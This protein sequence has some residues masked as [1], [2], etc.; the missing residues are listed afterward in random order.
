MP[1]GSRDGED[2]VMGLFDFMTHGVLFSMCVFGFSHSASCH[3][4]GARF[5]L[6]KVKIAWE[7]LSSS[8]FLCPNEKKISAPCHLV[9][10]LLFCFGE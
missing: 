5:G 3:P 4:I 1:F 7:I 8:V 9:R 6:M 10:L 2:D